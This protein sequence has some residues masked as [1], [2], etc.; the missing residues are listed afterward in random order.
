[1]PESALLNDPALHARW[2]SL[3]SNNSND[4]T[5]G[6]RNG[7]WGAA[8]LY[9]PKPNG[10]PVDGASL[11]FD[12][13]TWLG[14]INL[15]LTTNTV[16]LMAW[17]YDFNTAVAGSGVLFN[18]DGGLVNGLNVANGNASR[19]GFHWNTAAATFNWTGGPLRVFNQWQHVALRVSPTSVSIQVQSLGGVPTEAVLGGTY[20]SVA[21]GASFEIGRDSVFLSPDRWWGGYLNDV[22]VYSRTLSFNEVRSI[23]DLNSQ[24]GG[25]LKLSRPIANNL[26]LSRQLG[27]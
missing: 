18:R 5:A 11:E 25:M 22:R 27:G 9:E 8:P 24:D 20:A 3:G 26:R 10:V 13:T 19:W 4:S 17:V 15:G 1:M 16:T 23:A 6:G 21:V 2:A 14:G 12:R 7:T